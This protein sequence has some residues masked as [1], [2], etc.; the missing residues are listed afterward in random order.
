M[1]KQLLSLI[2][3]SE[4]QWEWRKRAWREHGVFCWRQRLERAEHPALTALIAT[5]LILYGL[6][7]IANGFNPLA[8]F[9]AE[10]YQRFGFA[11]PSLIRE[12]GEYWRLLTAVLVHFNLWHILFNGVALYQVGQVVER[13]Y[14]AARFFLVFLVSGI[15]GNILE[16]MM[17]SNAG[18]LG[19]AS[20]G[21]FGLIGFCGLYAH[22]MGNLALRRA[23]FQWAI[24][25]FVF[26]FFIRAAN[27][28]HFGGFIAGLAFALVLP[29]YRFGRPAEVKLYQLLGLLAIGLVAWSFFKAAT[30]WRGSVAWEQCYEAIQAQDWPRAQSA[31]KTAKEFLPTYQETQEN[32]LILQEILKKAP[33]VDR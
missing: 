5:L 25:A 11:F 12:H 29:P 19:G 1:K 16:W 31:C 22:R 6:M 17:M 9:S 15:A 18:V 3:L 30:F 32:W 33:P 27:L 21:V 7:V 24:Y 20:G 8:P 28:A 4:V 2:G 13:D 26:G 23:M 10:I 14:G